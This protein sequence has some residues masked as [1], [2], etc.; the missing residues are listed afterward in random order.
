ML[1]EHTLICIAPAEHTI[2]FEY[3]KGSFLVDIVNI[4]AGSYML[5]LNK[6]PLG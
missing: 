3:E 6:S 5:R 4:L 1:I 2:H